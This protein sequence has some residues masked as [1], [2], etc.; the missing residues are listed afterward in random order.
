MNKELLLLIDAIS[1]E[2]GIPKDIVIDA[3][4]AALAGATKRQFSPE[5]VRIRVDIEPHTGEYRAY[6]QW[7]VVDNDARMEDPARQVRL[8]DALDEADGDIEVGQFLEEEVPPPSLGRVAAQTVKQILVQRVR[9]GERVQVREAWADR[10][11]EMVLAEVKRRSGN[12]WHLDLGGG[13][14]ALL[15][16]KEQIPGEVLRVGHRVRVVALRIDE[17]ARGPQIV[18]SRTAPELLVALMAQEIPEVGEGS[19]EIKGCAREPGQRAKVAVFTHDRRVD[20]IGACIGMRGV[21]VQTISSELNG[22][23]MDLVLWDENPAS[24]V[25]NAMAPAQV[26]KMVVFEQEKRIDVGLAEDQLAKAIG[27]G[28]QNVRLASALTGWQLRALTVEALDAAGLEAD[29]KAAAGLMESLDLDDEVAMVLVENGFSSAEEIA[30]CPIGE[31]LSVDGFDEDIVDELR[32]RA[33][34]VMQQ[35]A[36]DDELLASSGLLNVDG[37]DETLAKALI[38]AGVAEREALAELATDELLA[39][40][41]MSAGDA[42]KIILSARAPWFEDKS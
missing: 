31:L 15:P 25:A 11:G 4:Q 38:D 23:R 10:M 18:A 34:V 6:R 39:L 1:F 21:R 5:D 17:A 32:R 12:A 29:Q 30:F 28:G 27:R 14:E 42:Q 40:V 26:E 22:E 19:V 33:T 35:A 13:A 16:A 7:E 2:K 37:V 8:M 3:L 41:P 20:P 9:E 36:L 24:F